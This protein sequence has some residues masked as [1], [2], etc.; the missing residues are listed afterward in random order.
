MATEN[1]TALPGTDPKLLARFM[2]KVRITNSCW[3]WTSSLVGKGYGFFWHTK[4]DR[5]AHRL[6]YTMFNG[7]IPPGLCVLHYCDNPPCVN[8]GHL[9]LGTIV[10]NNADRDSKGRTARGITHGS[11]TKP[12]RV[13]RGER[14]G[15][16]KLTEDNVRSIRAAIATGESHCALG[17]QYG[18]RHAT[19]WNI[20]HR[21]T[22]A[23]LN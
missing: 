23:H 21:K 17:R 4:G 13:A 12:N 1:P 16:A 15:Q 14:S 5:L 6:A 11:R 2:E 18:V 19:I 20:A 8:P 10:E 7:P 9:Y 22:W 3:E